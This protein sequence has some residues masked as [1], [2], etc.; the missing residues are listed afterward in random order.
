M[1]YEL[2]KNYNVLY[3]HTSIKNEKLN[4]YNRLTCVQNKLKFKQ[5]FQ[6]IIYMYVK[7]HEF[8]FFKNQ[9]IY[10]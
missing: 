6:P 2:I 4:C 10:V 8:I 1:F 3:N 7:V 9:N 5:S